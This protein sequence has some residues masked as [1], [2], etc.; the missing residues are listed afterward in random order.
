[1]KVVEKY[2]LPSGV[3]LKNRLFFAPIS[4]MEDA[5]DGKITENELAFFRQRTGKVG[6]IVVA[7]AYVSQNGRGYGNNISISHDRFIPSLSKIAQTIQKNETKAILQIYHGGANAKRRDNTDLLY[8]VSHQSTYLEGSNDYHELTET[9]IQKNI[10][11]YSKAILRAVKAGFDGVEL[12]VAN[13]YLPNQFL[14]PNWNLRNDQWGGSLRKRVK[15][16]EEIIKASLRVIQENKETPFALGIRFSLEDTMLMEDNEREKS[17]KE[18]LAILKILDQLGLDYIH[19]TSSDCLAK[20]ELNN[21][22]FDLL[23]I[24]KQV[25]IKTPVI[26]SGNLLQ[27]ESV[28]QALQH[29]ELASACRPFIFVPNWAEKIVNQEEVILPEKLLTGETRQTYN[30]PRNLWRGILETPDWY[31]YR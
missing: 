13:S 30:I 6:A 10:S 8:C 2:K 21:N 24:I 9:E 25:V 28:E 27:S 15:F 4:T 7:S 22:S 29:T 14:L 1:M 18:S 12:H 5:L 17:F 31:L 11:D 23:E 3:E 20:K 19:L 26:S 16:T